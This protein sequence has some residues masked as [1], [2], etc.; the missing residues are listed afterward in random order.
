MAEYLQSKQICRYIF[1]MVVRNFYN[2][3]VGCMG[4]FC[5]LFLFE[6]VKSV[7]F[8][9]PKSFW[10]CICCFIDQCNSKYFGITGNN[11][12]LFI[13]QEEIMF[14][15]N[16]TSCNFCCCCSWKLVQNL[17]KAKKSTIR[18]GLNMFWK[19]E[20]QSEPFFNRHSF[21]QKELIELSNYSL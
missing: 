5:N 19:R 18:F 7:W 13:P 17:L 14:Y 21:V 9:C 6:A 15:L 4:V 20:I 10:Y 8:M 11:F 2:I 12:K 16:S 1:E 3:S